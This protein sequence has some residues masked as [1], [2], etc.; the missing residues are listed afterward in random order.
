MIVAA[1]V[2][3]LISSEIVNS[4]IPAGI[5]RRGICF[6]LDGKRFEWNF[7]NVPFGAL[8]CSK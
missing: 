3:G 6:T 8:R 4:N 1:T 7:L 2:C 5:H